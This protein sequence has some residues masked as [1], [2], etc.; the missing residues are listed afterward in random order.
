MIECFAMLISPMSCVQVGVC[1]ASSDVLEV[2]KHVEL[3][4]YVMDK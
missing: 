1:R 2:M 4:R 3:L